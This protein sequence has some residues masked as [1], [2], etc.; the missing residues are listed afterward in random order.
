MSKY[1]MNTQLG[2]IWRRRE[3]GGSI[4]LASF[5]LSPGYCGKPIDKEYVVYIS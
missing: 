1:E 3:R 2:I 4:S 5:D